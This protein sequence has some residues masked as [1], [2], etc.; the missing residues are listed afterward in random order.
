M[1]YLGGMGAATSPAVP[2]P[3]LGAGGPLDPLVKAQLLALAPNIPDDQ[4]QD[5]LDFV[6]ATQ[7][8]KRAKMMRVGLGLAGGLVLGVVIGKVIGK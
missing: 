7:V 4:A 2:L 5:L 8:G 3:Q 6:D 1:R